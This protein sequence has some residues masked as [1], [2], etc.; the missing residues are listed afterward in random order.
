MNMIPILY[1][2]TYIYKVY[3][4]QLTFFSFFLFLSKK[5]NFHLPDIIAGVILSK[6]DKV[7][8]SY[9]SKIKDKILTSICVTEKCGSFTGPDMPSN[10]DGY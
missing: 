4:K 9:N 5:N 7:P 3:K 10:V 2:H 6:K 1:S 8:F